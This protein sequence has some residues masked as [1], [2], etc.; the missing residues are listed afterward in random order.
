MPSAI[1][2]PWSITAIR[3]ASSIG[4][5]QVLGGQ[6]QRGPLALRGPGSQPQIS[7][8]A[9]RIEPGGRLVEEQDPGPRQQARGE[10]EP[11][12]HPAGVGPGRAVGRIGEIERA[13]AADRRVRRASSRDRSNRRPNIS[14]FSRPVSS[15]STA[16]NCPVRPISS[17]TAAG[18]LRDVV[19]KDL[20]SARIRRDERGKDPD[21][22]GL[23]RA[24]RAE[25]P[26]DGSFRNLEIDSLQR[27]RFAEA[28]GDPLDPDR[29]TA[30]PQLWGLRPVRGRHHG[31]LIPAAMP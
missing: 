3:S 27:L 5:L 13:R 26:E 12:S 7:V 2:L 23:A 11:P 30:A 1:T 15:S 14:R 24:V 17:R 31:R 4:L 22:G 25:Q 16:A 8:A 6:Q 28:L 19:A 18:S 21:E 10:V 9:A 29:R 20:G